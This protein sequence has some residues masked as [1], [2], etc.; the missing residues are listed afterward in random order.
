MSYSITQE[1]LVAFCENTEKTLNLALEDN[2]KLSERVSKLEN[3]K[4]IANEKNELTLYKLSVMQDKINAA[5]Q[6]VNDLNN[7]MMK[8]FAYKA[9]Q[10]PVQPVPP[11][12]PTQ[13]V[14]PVPGGVPALQAV[15][16]FKFS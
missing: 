16:P 2:K 6:K 4:L 11:V 14:H 13:P 7:I 12:H 9:K 8:H 1:Q 3:E 15:Q 10:E 5:E